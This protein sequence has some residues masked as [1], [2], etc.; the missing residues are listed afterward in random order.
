V[1]LWVSVWTEVFRRE[2]ASE[3]LTISADPKLRRAFFGRFVST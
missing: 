2:F 1:W 3:Y